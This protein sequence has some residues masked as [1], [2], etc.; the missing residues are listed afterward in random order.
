MNNATALFALLL[1]FLTG[2]VGGLKPSSG[3]CIGNE[4]FRV[5]RNFDN[6]QSANS[7][8]R[9]NDGHLMTVRS[10]VSHDT[11]SI[12]LG[13][14]TGKFWIGLHLTTGCPDDA[15]GLKGYEWVT[16]DRESDL[17][18]WLPGF[19]SSCSAPRC[20]SVSEENDFKWTQTSCDEHVEG[21]LCEN[22]FSEPCKSLSVGP[23]ESV[24]YI[25]PYGFG[26]DDVLSLPPG[27]VATTKPSENNYLCYS[28]NWLQAPW[29][30]EILH[31][32]CEHKCAVGPDKEPFCYCPPGQI[33]HPVN[34]VT[35]Q[36][37]MTGDACAPLSCEQLCHKEGDSYACTCVDGFQ[38]ASDGRSCVDFNDCA[39]KR[40]CPGENLWCVNT[41]GSFKCVCQEGFTMSGGLCVDVDECESGPCEHVCVNALGSYT[42]VCY[43]GYKMDQQSQKCELYCGKAE[44]PAQCDPNNK[45]QCYCPQGYVAEERDTGVV[46]IDIDECEFSYCDQDC[47]NFY[48]G[49]VC[50]CQPGY[51]LVDEVKCIKSEDEDADGGQEG[52]GMTSPTIS[53][54]PYPGP[55]RRPSAVTAG[56]LVGI[57][58][59]TVFF[60]VLLVFVIH[61]LLSRR[62]EM[63][64]AG[65]L[66]APEGEAHGLQHVKSDS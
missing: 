13:N 1:V 6:F 18:N 49:Y 2:P 43:E 12:L 24:S 15:A 19:D 65:A 29:S 16:K 45:F 58:V 63:E 28:E 56:G 44:C 42:C 64:S 55:T 33:V 26:G 10:S 3:Y 52:S 5:F 9:N 14:F 51:T 48:G 20:V 7:L 31:G 47:K 62:R 17:T 41:V 60:V 30:C 61:L 59:C 35:C 8:C 40:H 21:F 37:L 57:I 25:T 39:D 11:L 46:C 53:L 22:S 38:L 34:K 23:E 66:K 50:L 32:G 4:C 36:G 27:S 54:V